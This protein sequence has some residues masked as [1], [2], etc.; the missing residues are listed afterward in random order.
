H[1]ARS[2]RSAATTRSKSNRSDSAK[3]PFPSHNTATTTMALLQ[4]IDLGGLQINVW[5]VLI[6]LAVLLF[7]VSIGVL[8][9]TRYKRCPSNRILVIYGKVGTGQSARC[10]HGGGT[11]VWPLVQ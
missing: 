4:S 10:L 11:F 6:V 8:L 3:L 2:S 1:T 7:A 9:V 5:A